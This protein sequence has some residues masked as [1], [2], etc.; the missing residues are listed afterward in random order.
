MVRSQHS[1]IR[2][3]AHV[4]VIN[5]REGKGQRHIEHSFHMS[6]E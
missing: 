4:K 2:F 6:C 1:N 5:E 3:L